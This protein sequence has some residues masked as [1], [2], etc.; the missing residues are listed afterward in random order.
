[1]AP[2]SQRETASQRKL[3]ATLVALLG[4]AGI[5]PGATIR[6]AVLWPLR[7]TH[8]IRATPDSKNQMNFG[9]GFSEK[10]VARLS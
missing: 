4:N 8:V 7:F 2:T 10:I 3:H 9:G 5:I 6:T 1:M